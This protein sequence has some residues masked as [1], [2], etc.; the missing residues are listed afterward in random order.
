MIT[1]RFKID[2]SVKT[3][4]GDT[5]II[6]NILWNDKKEEWEYYL[7]HNDCIDLVPYV[8]TELRK[9][10]KYNIVY[11]DPPWKYKD[12]G[13]Y[14][15]TFPKR[16]QVRPLRDLPYKS[17]NTEQIKSLPIQDYIDNNCVLL[18]WCNDSH[19][20]EGLDVIKAWGFAYKVIAFIWV[21]KTKN[22]KLYANTG[23]WTMKN[24]EICLLA[25]K[26][27][28]SRYKLINNLYQVIE[29]DRNNHSEKPDIFRAN[30]VKLFGDLPRIE[31]FARKQ[32]NGWDTWG[33]QVHCDINL[34][35]FE[36]P[37]SVG[38]N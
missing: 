16:K 22:G 37:K 36:K 8:S 6:K 38:K 4:L 32:F 34:N 9:I 17:M 26:G 33:D 3:M 18:M 11:A 31:L 21:K 2:E 20:Q 19:I 14:Q 15:E 23:A 10:G 35:G 28:M 1:K 25:T 30:I 27:A 24:A 13:V 7:T 5:A 12:V 29:H